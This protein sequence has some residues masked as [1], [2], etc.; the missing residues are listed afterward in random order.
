MLRVL[1]QVGAAVHDDR[2]SLAEPLRQLLARGFFSLHECVFFEQFRTTAERVSLHDFQDRTG[3]ECFV[4][5][6]HINDYIDKGTATYDQCA[7]AVEFAKTLAERLS[8][9]FP[10][11]PFSVIVGCGD[12]DAVI[13]F[14]VKREAEHFLATDLESYH[15]PIGVIEE[16]PRAC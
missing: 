6:I 11:Q 14:H 3:L 7:Q 5:H 9:S 10:V 13:R 12:D 2:R 8:R 15:E 16:A 1:Q 4:N